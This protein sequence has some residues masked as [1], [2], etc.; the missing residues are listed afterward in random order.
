MREIIYGRNAARET[1]RAR[2][3]HVHRVLFAE[4]VK[5]APVIN[6]ITTLTQR[7]KIPVKR[8]P[9][10]ELDKLGKGHQGVALEVG[11]YPTVAVQD[12]LTRAAK[13]NEPPF[14]AVLDHI[15]DP[16]NVGAIL[17][18][19]EIVVV[20]GVIIPR[21]RAAKITP[22][23]VNASAGASEYVWVAEVP[24]LVQTL[25]NLKQENVWIAGLEGIPEAAPYHTTN[26]TG[27]IAMVVGSE[28]KG[29][30]RLIKETC[31]FLVKL[32]MRGKI[33]SLKR[34]CGFGSDFVRNLA[35]T[36]FC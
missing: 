7:A 16:H 20:H 36:G 33:N 23:V 27:A 24:N 14:I 22:A 5:A 32:P 3:R 34:L 15:E 13:L 2:R 17:R 29:L 26:L 10:N 11:S 8:I 25:K 31:D 21:Q 18:T 12:I 4:N 9:R 6:E 35:R 19:A 28:G 1:L 30:G